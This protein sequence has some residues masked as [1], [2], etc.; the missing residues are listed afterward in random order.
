MIQLLSTVNVIHYLPLA[1]VNFCIVTQP[2]IS[3]VDILANFM[4]YFIMSLYKI[5]KDMKENEVLVKKLIG[6]SVEHQTYISFL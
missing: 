5:M 1:C 6:D 4:D 3:I 2:Q